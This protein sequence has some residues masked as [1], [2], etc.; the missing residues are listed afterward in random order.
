MRCI[1]LSETISATVIVFQI[2][3]V[4]F[5]FDLNRREAAVLRLSRKKGDS[6]AT[7]SSAV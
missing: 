7:F 6:A 1:E 2:T 4:A 3:Q 5:T